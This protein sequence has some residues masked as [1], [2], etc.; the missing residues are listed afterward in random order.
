M[1]KKAK[2]SPNLKKVGEMQEMKIRLHK[3][4]Y[5]ITGKENGKK[6]KRRKT[7]LNGEKMENSGNLNTNEEEVKTGLINFS[8]GSKM[9]SGVKSATL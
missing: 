7:E 5:S 2:N 1:K 8:F 3:V 9:G 6:M 4:K